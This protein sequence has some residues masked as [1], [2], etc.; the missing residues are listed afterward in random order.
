MDADGNAYITG[1]TA[2]TDFPTVNPY[3]TDQPGYDVF[4]VK[5]G[6]LSG[7]EPELERPEKLYLLENYPNPFN[8]AT[9]LTYNISI[10]GHARGVVKLS[11]YNIL[12]QHVAILFEGMQEA[13]EHTITWDATAFPSGVYFARLETE[14]HSESIKMV[15]LK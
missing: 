14:E 8:A 1:Y 11:I 15:L 13:G 5:Y 3:Q 9:I 6:P 4:V 7:I 12:G 2:S 10:P